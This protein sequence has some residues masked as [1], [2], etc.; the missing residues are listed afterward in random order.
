MSSGEIAIIK[1][2]PIKQQTGMESLLTFYQLSKTTE[3]ANTKER[4]YFNC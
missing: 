2:H 1:L 4:L 3:I